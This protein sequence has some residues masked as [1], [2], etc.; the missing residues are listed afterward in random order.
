MLTD[1]INIRLVRHAHI[2][3]IHP[4]MDLLYIV[5]VNFTLILLYQS[6]ILTKKITKKKYNSCIFQSQAISHKLITY[7]YNIQ[8][9]FKYTL[10]ILAHFLRQINLFKVESN[11]VSLYKYCV[12]Y[13]LRNVPAPIFWGGERHPVDE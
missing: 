2:I 3:L 8:T 9:K 13:I 4:L 11:I 1:I 5:S 10:P 6:L 7:N 12:M